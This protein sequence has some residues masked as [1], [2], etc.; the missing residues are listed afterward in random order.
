MTAHPLPDEPEDLAALQ[1]LA[2]QLD[3][4]DR[5]DDAVAVY[6]R[7]LALRPG[8]LDGWYNLGQAL[9]RARRFEDALAAYQRA[10]DGGITQPEEVHLNRSVLLAR[11]L[12]RPEAARGELDRALA[13]NPRYAPAWLNL[14]NL[15]EQAGDRDGATRAYEQVLT[16]APQHALAL[17]RLP[18]LRRISDPQDPLIRRLQQALAWPSLHPAD[19]ADLG[20]GLGKALDDAGRHDEAFAAF[21]EANT[22]SRAAA[23]PALRYDA[24]AHAAHVDRLIARFAAPAAAAAASSPVGGDE[25]LVFICG[26]FRSGSTLVERVLAAH[27]RVT[28]GGE[29]DLLPDIARRLTPPGGP[30]P[31]LDDAA[32]LQ[33]AARD[34][35]HAVAARLPQATTAGRITDKR[36]DNFLHV[37]LIKTLFPR[38]RIVLTRRHPLDNGLSMYFLHL[39]HTMPY[40]LDLHDLGHWMGQ[41]DRLVAHW[42]RLYGPDLHAVDYDRFVVDPDTETRRLL[43]FCGLDWHA[44][45]L[46]FH[47]A[48]G[49]VQTASLWQVRQPLYRHASGRWRHYARHLGPLREALGWPAAEASAQ[50]PS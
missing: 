7:L 8:W 38:A 4:S 1:A 39:G 20:F 30:W 31:L 2:R 45:C 26:L 34:Y 24:A 17:S 23:G 40:A 11:H 43:D 28:A 50:P 9:W 33:A 29:L 25:P 41:H 44:G 18:N 27:P 16:L 49:T 19:R 13:L 22:A 15:C 3:R 36:P 32:A 21:T 12:A 35:R 5:H 6:Q 46:D 47:T 10:L 14:G 48:G 42:Q 37:G